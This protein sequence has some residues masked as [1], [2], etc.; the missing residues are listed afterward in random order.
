MTATP[1][2]IG[3]GIAFP[4]R[5][6]AHGDLAMSGEEQSVRDAIAIILGTSP[7]ERVMRP[8][9][10]CRVHELVFDSIDALTVGR[11]EREV[12]VALDRWEPRIDVLDVGVRTEDAFDGQLEIEIAY[13]LRASN[14][15]RNLVYPFYVIPQEEA[16]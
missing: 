1:S 14:D 15:V 7:G 13:R 5:F 2:I 6:D 10:G 12:R 3:I 16:A 8:E 11:V 9:F 4:M